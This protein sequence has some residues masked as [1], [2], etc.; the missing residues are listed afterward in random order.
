M[1]TNNPFAELSAFISPSAMRWYVVLMIILVVVGTILDMMHKQSAKYFFENSKR[2]EKNAKRQL[3]SAE[4]TGLVVQT[5]TSE[6]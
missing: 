4:R 2:A 3:S 5:V 1:I 6:V